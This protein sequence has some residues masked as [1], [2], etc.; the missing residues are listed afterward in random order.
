[1][2]SDSIG[3][4]GMRLESGMGRRRGRGG[5]EKLHEVNGGAGKEES[6]SINYV[7][8]VEVDANGKTFSTN[9]T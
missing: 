3:V 7:S 9:L 1:M 6:T 2:M 8:E 4:D 5:S